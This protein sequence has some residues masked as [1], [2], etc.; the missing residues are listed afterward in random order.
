VSVSCIKESLPCIE[1]YRQPGA[2]L[3][4]RQ[5]IDA[6]EAE[7]RGG[8][9]WGIRSNINDLRTLRSLICPFEQTIAIANT[10]SRLKRI[11]QKDQDAIM[12]W[13]HAICDAA[14]RMRQVQQA[15]PPAGSPYGTFAV[16]KF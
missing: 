15:P 8:A 9:Y 6:F 4:V 2:R 10:P 11:E 1:H 3:R 14:I 16:P 5:L 12:D 7:I 13:G